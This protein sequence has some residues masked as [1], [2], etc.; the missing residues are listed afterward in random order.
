[1]RVELPW[2]EIVETEAACLVARGKGATHEIIQA[3][4]KTAK[5]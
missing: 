3:P 5:N 1:M 2:G 4:A